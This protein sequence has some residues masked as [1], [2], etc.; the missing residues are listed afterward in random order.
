MIAENFADVQLFQPNAGKRSRHHARMMRPADEACVKRCSRM[1]TL[2]RMTKLLSLVFALIAG[3]AHTAN[4]QTS[5]GRG[6]LNLNMGAQIQDQTFTDSSTFT[7]Y[8][9]TGA[10][11]AGHTVGGGQLFDI[12][13]GMRVWRS[14]SIGIGYSTISNKNDALVTARVPHP[15]VFGQSRQAT[16]TAESL[17]HSENAVHLQF[18]WLIPLT[19]KFD[20]SVFAGPSFFTVRQD[21]ATIRA[22]QDIR[23]AAPFTSVTITS[24]SI[25]DVKDS[26][27]GVHIGVDGTY[28][29]RPMFGVGIFLR[30]A[31]ASLELPVTAGSTRDEDLKAGGFQAGG[32]LR[33][34]F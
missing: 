27:V 8:G 18:S 7:I 17:E 4:A 34:R 28:L 29:V 20:V 5:D 15:I 11:A 16:V 10:V 23:D 6:Y 3:G 25:T 24:V 14:L 2:M 30:Y 21:V 19:N 26:A 33:V 1:D 9:E 12:S 31:G 32:G 22:P 13:A